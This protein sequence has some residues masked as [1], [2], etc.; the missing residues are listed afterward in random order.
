LE[1]QVID[2]SHNMYLL[3]ES[4]ANNF[5][6]FGE[7]GGSNIEVGMDEKSRDNEDLEDS[8]KSQRNRNQAPMSSLLH[9]LCLKWNQKWKLNPT[10]V[11]L[12]LLS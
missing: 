10:K 6:P 8:K 2:I 12:L 11:I 7:V 3:M 5:G 4:L 1:E 9:N